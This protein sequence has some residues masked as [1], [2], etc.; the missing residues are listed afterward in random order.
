LSDTEILHM[1]GD[2][3][4]EAVEIKHRRTGEARTVRTP[5][6]FTFIGAIPC[7]GWLP[8]EKVALS[9]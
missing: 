1:L 7:T 4:L 3:R 6:V 5:A 8:P 2:Q 9:S